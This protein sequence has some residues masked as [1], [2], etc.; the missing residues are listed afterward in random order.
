MITCPWCGTSYI[1]FQS[2]CDKCGGPLPPPAA[3]DAP[4][5]GA[6]R[7]DARPPKPP[8][9]PRAI[10]DGYAWRLMFSDGW[11]AAALVFVL[12]GG[13]FTLVGAGL[14]LGI[15]TAF[16]GLPFVGLGLLFLGSG[17]AVTVWRYRLARQIVLVLRTGEAAAG[18]IVR[19]EEN[20]NVRVNQRHPWTIH[21]QF[22]L[23]DQPID[24]QVSTLN[25]PGAGLQPG[26]PAW[27]LYLPGAPAQNVLYPHP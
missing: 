3:N 25:V 12:L 23:N 14:T 1:S 17:I 22:R 8:L 27:V 7:Q 24:G 26:Q 20:L 21:Y 2:N 11:A 4:M 6:G 15:I 5:P 10:S 19:V 9:P 16:I 18:Q 13:T